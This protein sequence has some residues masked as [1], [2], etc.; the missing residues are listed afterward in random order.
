MAKL[1]KAEAKAH[2]EAVALLEK[3]V[4]TDDD[5]IFFMENWQ[6][7]ANHVNSTAGAFF[8]PHGLAR[9]AAIDVFNTGR[10]IDLCA[11]IGSLSLAVL[12]NGYYQR[13]E[14][15]DLL[16]LVCVELNPEYVE[17]GKKI[18][19]EATWICGS[20]FDLPDLGHF[21]YA[22]SNPP[23]GNIKTG[24]DWRGKYTGSDFEFRTI[25]VASGI[26]DYGM[27]IIPQNSAGFRYSGAHYYEHSD[28][29]RDSFRAPKYQKFS[30]QTGIRLDSG[31]GVDTTYYK[32][33]WH[34]VS[35]LVEIACADFTGL[36]RTIAPRTAAKPMDLRPVVEIPASVELIPPSDDFAL[37][38]LE[39][40]A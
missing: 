21:D 3:D 4:L 1:S 5:R 9:D 10:V 32:D 27:F 26:A 14:S 17:I 34:G 19:P 20:I 29:G 18:L 11:G 24:G 2:H 6:E 28:N 12:W 35:P 39:D 15:G 38:D 23:F 7:S 8:T 16:E 37:F 36:E 33:D 22:I 31:A 40:T 30:Q 13:Q 25:E